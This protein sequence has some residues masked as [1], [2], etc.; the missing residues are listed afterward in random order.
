MNKRRWE[1]RTE[2]LL[3][4]WAIIAAS[5]YFVQKASVEYTFDYGFIF[6]PKYE[7]RFKG[8]IPFLPPGEKIEL[9][10]DP[11]GAVDKASYLQRQRLAKYL[12][13]PYLNQGK[14]VISDFHS[15]TNLHEI[16]EDR[17]LLLVKDFGNGVGLFVRREKN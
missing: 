17:K 5:A 1:K 10:T 13:T 2:I 12:L 14:Y 11:P 3:I 16:A 7:S 6:E 9:I 15:T 4:L 8:A